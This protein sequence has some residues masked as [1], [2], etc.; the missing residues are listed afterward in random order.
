MPLRVSERTNN[1]SA[2]PTISRFVLSRVSL[3]AFRTNSSSSTMFVLPI[4][5]IYT[6]L[7]ILCVS[8]GNKGLLGRSA[9]LA[10]QILERRNLSLREEFLD[11]GMPQALLMFG[12][13]LSAG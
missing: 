8:I 2:L 10:H 5:A 12:R 7:R 9:R 11:E 6:N 4:K 13:E 1:S 3:R